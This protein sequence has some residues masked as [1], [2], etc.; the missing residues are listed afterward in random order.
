[1]RAYA[2]NQ[3]GIGY[4]DEIIRTQSEVRV[5]RSLLTIQLLTSIMISS[6]LY[7]SGQKMWLSYAENLIPMP[8]GQVWCYL[9]I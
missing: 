8:S 4:G 6:V 7:R 9:R 2:V 5:H 1:M 3:A